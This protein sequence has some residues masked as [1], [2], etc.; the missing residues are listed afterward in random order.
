MSAPAPVSRAS[1]SARA[2]SRRASNRIACALSVRVTSRFATLLVD[3]TRAASGGDRD[4]HG[5]A[6]LGLYLRCD[7]GVLSQPLAGVVLALADLVAVVGIPGPR[8]FDD[9]VRHAELDDFALA[10]NTF[11]IEN[12]E[13]RLA[14]RRRDLVLDHLDPGFVADDFFAALDRPN[15][16]DV[17]PDRSIELERVAAAGRLRVAEHHSDLHPNLID[18]NDQNIGALDIR[19]ELAQRLA[20]PP[21]LQTGKLV[22]HFAFD[23]R[24]RHERG[25]RVDDND[26]DSAR[27]HQHVGDFE[28]LLPR[29]RLGDEHLAHI[30]AELACIDRIESVLGVDIGR[31]SAGLLHLRD[32]LKAERRL[33]GGFGPVDLDHTPARQAADTE[34]DI[35]A[36]RSGRHDLQIV[37]DLGLAH[38]HDRAL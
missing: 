31:D 19:R 11:A 6:D 2:Y 12:I 35:E 1:S 8:L 3:R 27:A 5:N 26:V 17:E 10:R 38:P 14:K 37:L 34:R 9:V 16:A 36:E 18:E 21:R 32:H 29:V 13:Q 25:D 33:A 30:D 15:A 7:I 4:A 28:A 22:A 20:H 24:L 23:F